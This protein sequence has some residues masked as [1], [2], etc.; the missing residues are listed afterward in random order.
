MP[1]PASAR[2]LVTLAIFPSE[3]EATLAKNALKKCGVRTSF[4][5]GHPV[6]MPDG[7]PNGCTLVVAEKDLEDA[8]RILSD[9]TG[10]EA[11]P[12]ESGSPGERESGDRILRISAL[13]FLFILG[14]AMLQA[15]LG[16]AR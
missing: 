3:F 2:T 9:V 4:A 6:L 15:L 16:Y 11:P 1:T 10:R 12:D 13:A 7:V 8:T 14:C 5:G